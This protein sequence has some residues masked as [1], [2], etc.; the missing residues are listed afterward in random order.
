MK[1]AF[2]RAMHYRHACKLFDE[3]RRIAPD[4]DLQRSGLD[5]I[6]SGAA[7]PRKRI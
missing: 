4:Y 2:I 3:N 1:N 6:D 5:K 7:G